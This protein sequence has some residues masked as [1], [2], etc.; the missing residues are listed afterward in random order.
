MDGQHVRL[1]GAGASRLYLG[2]LQC[3]LY[4]VPA[5][6]RFQSRVVDKNTQIPDIFNQEGGRRYFLR[7][8]YFMADAVRDQYKEILDDLSGYIQETEKIQAEE[9]RREEKR[10]RYRDYLRRDNRYEY[11]PMGSNKP[12]E[13]AET[14]KESTAPADGKPWAETQPPETESSA[15]DAAAENKETE[16][17]KGNKEN[18]ENQETS[19]S[20]GKNADEQHAES[21]A[22]EC[23][24]IIVVPKAPVDQYNPKVHFRVPD[25]AEPYI[26]VGTAKKALEAINEL[27]ELKKNAMPYIVVSVN[28]AGLRSIHRFRNL[29]SAQNYMQTQMDAYFNKMDP[30][31]IGKEIIVDDGKVQKDQAIYNPTPGN[32]LDEN[33]HFKRP[34]EINGKSI[35]LVN[36][37]RGIIHFIESGKTARWDIYSLD[38]AAPG[39]DQIDLSFLNFNPEDKDEKAAAEEKSDDANKKKPKFS[40]FHG[41]KEKNAK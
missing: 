20:D 31:D 1:H 24:D 5:N 6:L 30:S 21:D 29:I 35:R 8:L 11:I 16:S 28:F 23:E 7:L 10:E 33:G 3:C 4:A 25:D 34:S 2:K 14:S 26:P 9:K 19:E 39:N 12:V 13:N 17:T 38:D 41:R 40:F 18:K 32:E 15:P 22:P 37:K 27:I 36:E